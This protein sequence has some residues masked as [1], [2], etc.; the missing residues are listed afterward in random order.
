MKG[1]RERYDNGE[2]LAADEQRKIIA[3]C[4]DG[5][6]ETVETMALHYADCIYSHGVA[7]A[8]KKPGVNWTLINAAILVRWSQSSLIR[9]KKKAWRSLG[10]C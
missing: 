1:V 8:D 4:Q 7:L 5:K 6:G 2:W 9:I 10:V 3:A